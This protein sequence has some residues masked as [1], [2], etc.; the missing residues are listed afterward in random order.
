MIHPFFIVSEGVKNELTLISLIFYL[1][2][3]PA[4]STAEKGASHCLNTYNSF[5]DVYQIMIRFMKQ[6]RVGVGKK[7]GECQVTNRH[8]SSQ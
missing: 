2:L 6:L 8:S 4:E 1:L 5:N 7:N 3:L